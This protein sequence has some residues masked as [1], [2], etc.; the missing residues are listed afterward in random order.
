MEK[1]KPN[2]A[3]IMKSHNEN[4]KNASYQDEK[5]KPK[6]VMKNLSK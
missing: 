3:Q 2:E 1:V 5:A 6:V 4:K